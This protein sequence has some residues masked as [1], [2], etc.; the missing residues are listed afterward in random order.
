MIHK[1]IKIDWELHFEIQRKWQTKYACFCVTCGHYD[2][3]DERDYQKWR[4]PVYLCFECIAFDRLSAARKPKNTEP[5][6]WTQDGRLLKTAHALLF[7]LDREE[8]E[9]RW[10]AKTGMH[11]ETPT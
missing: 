2:E 1:K 10:E 11:E 4:T 9:K 8:S 7:A 3:V 5:I 6:W